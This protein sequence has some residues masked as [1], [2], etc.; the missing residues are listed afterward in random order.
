MRA[1]ICDPPRSLV[2]RPRLSDGLFDD[3]CSV[4]DYVVE[5]GCLCH[6]VHAAV[7]T[8]AQSFPDMFAAGYD[9]RV[10]GRCVEESA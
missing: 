8:S 10:R 5:G 2:P 4:V 7:G 6:H 1:Q 3:D 9:R